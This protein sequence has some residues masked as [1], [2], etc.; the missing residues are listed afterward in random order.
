META[1][2]GYHI[3]LCD[4]RGGGQSR[5]EFT[6]FANEKMTGTIPYNGRLI[7]RGVM[8]RSE[9]SVIPITAASRFWQHPQDLRH[10][11]RQLREELAD[12]FFPL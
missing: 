12:G 6:P 10:W 2:K 5:G 8:E 3:L 9:P 1:F 11:Q 7:S 4:V